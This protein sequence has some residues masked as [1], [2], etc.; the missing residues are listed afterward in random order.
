MSVARGTM[1][2]IEMEK[3]GITSDFPEAFQDDLRQEI[4]DSH[5]GYASEEMVVMMIA[6]QRYKDATMAKA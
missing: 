4:I 1:D 3:L 5:C 6:A 2:E